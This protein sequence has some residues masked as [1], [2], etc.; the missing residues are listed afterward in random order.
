MLHMNRTGGNKGMNAP[1]ISAGQCF[2]CSVNVRVNRTR[3]T[4]DNAVLNAVRNRLDR[5]EVA[6]TGN[7][8]PR[9]D[10]VHLQ[11]LQRPRD[12]Q[13]FVLGHGRARALLTISQ[14]GIKNKYPVLIHM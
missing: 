2:S 9:F 13:L 7:G 1:C 11:L 6:G 3:Q 14:R 8:K 5:L 12:T 4:T 10:D